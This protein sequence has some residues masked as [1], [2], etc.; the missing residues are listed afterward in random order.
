M[1]NVFDAKLKRNGWN[2][3]IQMKKAEQRLPSLKK[4]FFYF[5]K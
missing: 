5:L 2:S 1:Q 3:L 4:K